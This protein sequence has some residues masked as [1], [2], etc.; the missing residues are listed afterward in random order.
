MEETAAVAKVGVVV[1]EA[2]QRFLSYFIAGILLLTSAHLRAKDNR[3]V[4]LNNALRTS[5]VAFIVKGK[6]VAVEDGDTLKFEASNGSRFIVRLSDIDA[7]EI[8]HKATQAQCNCQTPTDKPGQPFGKAATQ[9]LKELAPIGVAARAECYET[10]AYGRLVCHVFVGKTNLNL[11]Q[12]HRGWA[13]TS[14]KAEWV[15]DP[16]SKIVELRA[17]ANG[18]GIWQL[19]NPVHP[20]EWRRRCWV[21]GLCNGVEN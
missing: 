4:H 17:K 9:S 12:L 5:K 14:G 1:I 3:D 8:F 19:K 6:V 11:E 16:E 2:M 20:A 18:A 10:D 13:M 21:D 7:P 15:R